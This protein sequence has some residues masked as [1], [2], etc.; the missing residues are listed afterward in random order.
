LGRHIS[1]NEMAI[2]FKGRKTSGKP[3]Q[4]DFFRRRLQSSTPMRLSTKSL[5][6]LMS[7]INNPISWEYGAFGSLTTYQLE[8]TGNN[9]KLAQNSI[10]DYQELV[11]GN[12]KLPYLVPDNAPNR[13]ELLIFEILRLA[14]SKHPHLNP[15]YGIKEISQK[16]L[17]EDRRFIGL[18]RTFDRYLDN[19]R[20]LPARLL[21]FIYRKARLNLLQWYA[22]QEYADLCRALNTYS[23]EFRTYWIKD[24]HLLNHLG[25]APAM[26][27]YPSAWTKSVRNMQREILAVWFAGRDAFTGDLLIN[28]AHLHH[29]Q[30]SNL[31]RKTDCSLN[32]NLNTGRLP[33]LVP[34]SA[35]SHGTVGNNPRYE[36]LF[37][38]ALIS[39]LKGRPP[40]HWSLANKKAFIKYKWLTARPYI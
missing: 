4:E 34:L 11:W 19:Q 31:L 39:V 32:F 37:R 6:D 36:S 38:D 5:K 25:L 18:R 13:D 40:K 16:T 35:R 24:Q 27:D 20:P 30:I 33:A 22:P 21:N 9:L 29:W 1:I 3:K 15:T 7:F 28:T 26:N 23:R 14:Y 8:L 12:A 2:M 10:M 17:F